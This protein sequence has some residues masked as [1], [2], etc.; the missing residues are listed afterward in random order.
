MYTLKKT[1]IS[2]VLLGLLTVVAFLSIDAYRATEHAKNSPESANY[3]IANQSLCVPAEYLHPKEK[4][5]NANDNDMLYLQV[6][7][8]DLKPLKKTETEY[9]RAKEWWQN[10]TMLIHET[11]Y[12]GPL[13]DSWLNLQKDLRATVLTG[14]EY[15]LN[16]YTQPPEAVQ[17]MFDFWLE[18]DDTTVFTYI[19]CSEKKS[20]LSIP[21]CTMV[22]RNQD[23]IIVS[24]SF[25]KR[26]LDQWKVIKNN[27]QDLLETFKCP[28]IASEKG[29]S[30]AQ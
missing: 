4:Q 20:K 19:Y 9:R 29:L 24:T 30:D 10:L 12:D 5:S 18:E 21:H 14:Q 3:K 15:N 1:I 11:R 22:F 23:N 7:G 16:H 27:M 8:P 17:D 6:M 13:K 26:Q 28:L 25:N 2:I